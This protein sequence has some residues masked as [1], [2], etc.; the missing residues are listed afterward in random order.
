MVRPLFRKV[1]VAVNG[2][3]RSLNAAMYS[4]LLA[5]ELKC[6]LRAVYVVDVATLKQ[7]ELSK[8]LISDE[9]EKYREILVKDGEKYLSYVERLAEEKTVAL[10]AELRT[11]AVWTEI[12]AS[13]EEFG[14]D[15]ILLGGRGGVGDAPGGG[16]FEKFSPVA[17]EIASSARCNVLVVNED[18]Q[19]LFKLA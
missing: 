3:E 5:R 7:L 4:V 11:G 12:V 14:A 1:L 16:A 10:E 8:F 17:S 18:V 13:A 9:A 15:A 2:S 19:K 6:A